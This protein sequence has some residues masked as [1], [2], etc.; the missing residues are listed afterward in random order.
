[1]SNRM[2]PRADGSGTA[3][4]PIHVVIVGPTMMQ[5]ATFSADASLV[6]A[7]AQYV[8]PGGRAATSLTQL[9]GLMQ[10]QPGTITGVDVAFTGDVA[11]V[12]QTVVV[13]IQRSIDHG[14]TFVDVAG[15]TSGPIATTAGVH[16]ASV[17][18]GVPVVKS[19]GD[20]LQ[21]IFT[22]SALLGAVVTNVVVGVKGTA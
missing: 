4:N 19:E 6:N 20:I 5:L 12:A 9:A 11:N 21:A 22:P 2:L 1:M 15:A 18:M 7:A 8:P 17:T 10:S 14:A 13:K 16:F 3:Q